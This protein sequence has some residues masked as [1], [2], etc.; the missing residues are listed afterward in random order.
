MNF[1]HL[2][3]ISA[4]LIPDHCAVGV[5]A[6]VIDDNNRNLCVSVN[7]LGVTPVN[8]IYSE[9]IRIVYNVLN[10]SVGSLAELDI[11]GNDCVY[12]VFNLAFFCGKSESAALFSFDFTGLFVYGNNLFSVA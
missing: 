4:N 11:I 8:I 12:L 1:K 9:L 7:H 6:A 3:V 10:L 5:G 2:V